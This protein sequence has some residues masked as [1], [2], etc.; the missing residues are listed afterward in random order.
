LF[1]SFGEDFKPKEEEKGMLS[2]GL[3]ALAGFSS[4]LYS[5]TTEFAKS[6]MSEE[7]KK[8]F[9]EAEA[10]AKAKLAPALAK[11]KELAAPAV[12]WTDAKLNKAK[13]TIAEKKKQF[14]ASETGIY[15]K[16]KVAK[17]AAQ[18]AALMLALAQ[19][20][21]AKVKE[22]NKDNIDNVKKYMDGVKA[23]MGKE[24][25]EKLAPQ[26]KAVYEEAK[27]RG[28]VTGEALQARQKALE[29]SWK[30][31]VEPVIK[32]QIAK[33]KA[34][35]EKAKGESSDPSDVK[36]KAPEAAGET[37]QPA[38]EVHDGEVIE[39]AHIEVEAEAHVEGEIVK[40][41]S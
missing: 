13:E 6:K 18:Q 19:A 31:K 23:K 37:V 30:A 24:W 27:K 28:K 8:K 40:E 2:G 32:A 3:S 17:P 10:K 14:L 20:E 29:A 9:E 35:L 12:D 25:D 39:P 15:L 26:F 4:S 41:V 21:I 5:K 1:V 33:A 22:E 34:A 11:A 38:P 7:N 36:E 16:N